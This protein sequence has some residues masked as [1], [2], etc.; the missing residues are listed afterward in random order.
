[1]PISAVTGEGIETLTAAIEAQLG[2]SREILD[3]V[4]DPAD[5]AGASWLHRHTEVLDRSMRD[6]GR[7]AMT[8]RADPANA[9]RTRARF[10]L[11][12]RT[13]S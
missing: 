12:K 1:V 9:Q 2:R 7:L 5:G 8:V 4:L 10:G 6:D 3:L 11:A 13:S